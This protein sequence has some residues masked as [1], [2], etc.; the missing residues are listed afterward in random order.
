MGHEITTRLYGTEAGDYQ[1]V[2]GWFVEL[3][4]GPQLPGN[5]LPPHGV[6]V[7]VR[8]EPVAAMWVYLSYGIGVAFSEWA[9][10]NPS[11]SIFTRSRAIRVALEW[12]GIV[13]KGHDCKALF[14]HV[15]PHL[16]G[17]VTQMGMVGTGQK[18]SFVKLLD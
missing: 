8:G 13:A 9:I 1:L 7:S 17:V 6:I 18:T 2:D 3:G 4:L 15:L 12:V 16:S 14:C 5:L 11:A 10:T